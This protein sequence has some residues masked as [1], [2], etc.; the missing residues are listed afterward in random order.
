MKTTVVTGILGAGKTTFIQRFLRESREKTVV[1][2][3]DFGRS[4]IDGEVFSADGI[5]FIEL[6]S[7]C[8]CCTLKADLLTAV[9][10]IVRDF[11]PDHLVIEPSGVASPSGVLEALEGLSLDMVTVVGIV[12]ATEFIELYEAQ[13]YGTFF[14]DQITSSDVILIN[15]TDVADER[16]ISDAIRKVQ[17]LNEQAVI[18]RTVRGMMS[19]P[20]PVFPAN[21]R[22]FKKNACHFDFDT[23]SMKLQGEIE[24]SLIAGFLE[25]LGQGKYGAVARAKALVQTTEGPYRFDLSYGKTDRTSFS[26]TISDSRLVIIGESLKKDAIHNFFV[27]SSLN[28]RKPGAGILDAESPHRRSSDY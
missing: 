1:L 20:I 17:E 9:Q 7:G 5:E 21:R 18:V 28:E 6:P 15:K 12:D 25:E 2:V 11:S 23:L 19:E 16:K 10:R 27:S 22:D 26:G 3:N 4:G 24:L 13:M 14:E 8:V